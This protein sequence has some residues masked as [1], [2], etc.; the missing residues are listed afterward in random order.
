MHFSAFFRMMEEVEHEFPR[1]LGASVV[2]RDNEGVV[3][4]PRVHADCDYTGAV[5]FEEVLDIEPRVEPLGR[6]SAAY[7]FAFTAG[8]RPIATGRI[9]VV[10]CRVEPPRP[11]RSIPI[12]DELRQRFAPYVETP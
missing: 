3:S 1:S 8:D 9:N 12:S 5:R 10:R 2:T 7:A 11:L 4:W 6:S